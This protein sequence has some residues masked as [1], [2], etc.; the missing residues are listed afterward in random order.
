MVVEGGNSFYMLP[1]DVVVGVI[2]NF[3]DNFDAL[4]QSFIFSYERN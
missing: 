1:G 4:N 2:R 3:I